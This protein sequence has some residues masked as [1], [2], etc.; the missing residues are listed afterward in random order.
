[1]AAK[2]SSLVYKILLVAVAIVVLFSTGEAVKYGMCQSQCLE[3][4]PNCDAWCKRIG[5]PKG[6][7]CIHPRYIDCCCWE[8]QP[9]GKL[10]SRSSHDLHV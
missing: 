10:T 5:Y 4:Q 7:E 3:I 2:F 9:L 1:M 8:I 6:G